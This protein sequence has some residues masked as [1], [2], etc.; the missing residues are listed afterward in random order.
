ML[1]N[2]TAP[3]KKKEL[4]RELTNY[5]AI[6]VIRGDVDSSREETFTVQFILRLQHID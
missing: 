6:V 4:I 1:G 3:K 2:L 5:V